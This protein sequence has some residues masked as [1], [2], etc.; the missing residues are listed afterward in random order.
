M[1]CDY[2]KHITHHSHQNFKSSDA[3][4]SKS[5]WKNAVLVMML[6]IAHAIKGE[7]PTAQKANA[8]PDQ[9]KTMGEYFP[10]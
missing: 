9:L 6:Y 8:M 2:E 4:R 1:L 5:P 3:S 10:E 7:V